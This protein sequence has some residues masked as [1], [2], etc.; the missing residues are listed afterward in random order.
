MSDLP[1][2]VRDRIPDIIKES[3]ASCAFE[4]LPDLPDIRH[5]FLV[6]KLK[7]ETREF[8]EAVNSIPSSQE[9][10]TE[11]AAD[12]LQVCMDLWAVWDISPE[13]VF[14]ACIDKQQARGGFGEGVF[15]LSIRKGDPQFTP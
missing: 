7:E 8:E 3:G 12:M 11:E 15:L 13:D 1:K 2:L 9:A 4:I 6:E 10:K 14:A 5:H